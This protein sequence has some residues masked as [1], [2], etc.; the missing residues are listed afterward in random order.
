VSFLQINLGQ[1][2]SLING[3]SGFGVKL[4]DGFYVIGTPEAPFFKLRERDDYPVTYACLH[5]GAVIA[6]YGPVSPAPNDEFL[7]IIIDSDGGVALKRD[8]YATMPLFYSN[9]SEHFILS[10][11]YSYVFDHLKSVTLD[12]R[13]LMDSLMPNPDSRST[14]WQEIKIA[15]ERL[16]LERN[17]TGLQTRLPKEREWTFSKQAD[18]SDP[19][20]FSRRLSDHLENFGDLFAKNE[21]FAYEASGGLDSSSLPLYYS[22]ARPGYQRGPLN[23]MLLPGNF[24]VSQFAKLEALSKTT[25]SRNDYIQVDQ[26]TD[27]PLARFLKGDQTGGYYCFDEIY[28]EALKKLVVHMAG[29]GTRVV[30]TGIGG[31]ELFENTLS[32]EQQLHYG[33]I[34]LTRR[35]GASYPPFLTNRF[36]QEYIASTPDLPPYPMP[37]L[38]SS[39]HGA[40]TARNNIYINNDIWP[41]S[42]FADVDLYR[43]CQGLPA[44]FRANK[45]IL[46]AFHAA[47]KFPEVIYNPRQNEHFGDFFDESLASGKYDE[48]VSEIAYNSV[49][50]R[51]GLVDIDE[52][53]RI[54]NNRETEWLFHV[55][56]WLNAEIN[57]RLIG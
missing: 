42:P 19:K 57:L 52:L 7:Q 8:A 47:H 1:H 18:Q 9:S 22:Q 43:Y 26:E 15:G 54:Y 55:Y 41:V 4:I 5:E 45:N 31:D 32:A 27:F 53:I 39:L 21:G 2:D 28:S 33:L 20:H 14:L 35:K 40:Q 48:L 44:Q 36:R 50:V 34:E 13:G 37:L 12:Q 25:G 38:G 56:V 6:G 11:D 49:T 23:S 16:E 29:Q 3:S 10:N 30:A 46:R 24:G 51:L 17:S